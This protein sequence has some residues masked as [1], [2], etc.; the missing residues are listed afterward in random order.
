MKKQAK[1]LQ[2]QLGQMQQQ[3][4]SLRVTGE[5]GN[6]LVALTISGE[7][8]LIDITIKPECVDPDDIEGLQDL[9]VE[10]AKVA[11]TKIGDSAPVPSNLEQILR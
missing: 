4:Q 1:Q 5:A 9:I 6:G 11:Y 2:E 7:K 8:E 10:A 3:L